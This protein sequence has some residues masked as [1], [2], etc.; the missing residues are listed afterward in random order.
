MGSLGAWLHFDGELVLLPGGGG[1]PLPFLLLSRLPG[2]ETISHAYRFSV[3]TQLLLGIAAAFGTLEISR[4]IGRGR[5]LVAALVSLCVGAESLLVG[6]YPLPTSS[7]RSSEAY[8]SIERDGAVLDLPV[9]IQ[10][11]GR[12]RYAMYQMDH[13]RP[14]VYALDDPTPEFL[15]SNRMTRYLLNLERS[16]VDSLAPSLPYLEFALARQ[17]LAQQGLAAIVVHEALYPEDMLPRI[18]E[19]LDTVLGEGRSVDG[20]VIYGI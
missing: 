10:V 5:L 1:M 9:G 11:L 15:L 18:R 6:P 4:R 7:V 14:I 12:G 20:V 8:A 16:S 2:L 17:Q 19:F 3:L 13:G